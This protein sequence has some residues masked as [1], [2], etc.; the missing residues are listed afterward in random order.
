MKLIIL[1]GGFGTRLQSVLKGYPKPLADINGQPFI[2]FLFQDWINN[3][4]ND[5]ILSLH[6]EA[7][8]IIDFV[9]EEKKCGILKNCNIQSIIEPRPLGTGGAVAYVTTKIKLE[10]NIYITNADTWL[11]GGYLNLI[12][13]NGNTIGIVEVPNAYRYGRVNINEEN[14]IEEFSEKN[15]SKGPGYINAGFYKLKKNNFEDWNGKAFSI[16]KDL[17]PKL[18]KAK[19]LKCLTMSDKFI[20]IGIPDDY[21]TF[22]EWKKNIKWN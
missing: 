21:Y 5:F 4:F 6:Y 13:S 20:D 10:D 16:E 19:K 18:V 7:Q 14:L 11:N 2:K 3:G 17:F 22:C 8:M 12:K 9:D 15:N 1:A